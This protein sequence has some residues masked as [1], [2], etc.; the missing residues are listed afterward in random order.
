LIEFYAPWC[1]HCKQLAPEYEVAATAL[2]RFDPSVPLAKVDCTEAGKES[3]SKYGVTGYP[4]LKI[5]KNGEFSSEYSGPRDSSGIIKYMKSKA[6]PTTRQLDSEAALKKFVGNADTVVV[7]YFKDDS[8]SL[9]ATFKK[10]ADG[11]SEDFS[12]G[13]T[14]GSQEVTGDQIVIYYPARLHSKFEA[15]TKK[16]E[17]AEEVSQ[18]KSWIEEN[19]MGIV[20]HRTASNSKFFEQKPLVVVYYKVDYERN[21]KGTNYWRNRVM[22]VA[23][24]VL[25]SGKKATFAISSSADLSHELAEFGV[26]A[27]DDAVLYVT[28]KDSKNQK[29]KMN[30]V[31]NMETFETFLNDFFNNKLTVY[32]K[33]EPIP[34]ANDQAVKV[35]VA[36]NF[37]EIVNAPDKDVLI[38][39]YAPWC[40]HCKTLAPKYDELA[41][42]LKNEPSITI[43]KMDATANDVP[44]NFQVQGFP[45]LFF[46]PK[47]SKDAPRQY[48]G[49][50]EVKDFLEYIAR[51]STEPLKTFDRSGA[52]LKSEL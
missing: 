8:S 5:F 29:F 50:R 13:H 47:G 10:V 24:K 1:G 30:G 33:S 25:D 23:K 21:T 34:E 38:E 19:A 18:I 36:K 39:F 37:E 52:P 42:K 41:E 31:F 26:D 7:G 6:G 27:A 14:F 11:L 46:V 3:C 44:S 45:T 43:A 49:G 20:G 32:M 16:F 48:N 28:I 17:G 2:K 9:F 15:K 35:V 22:K 40:G 51:E 12:F 4:T